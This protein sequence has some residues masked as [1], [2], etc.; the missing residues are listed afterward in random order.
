VACGD[1]DC[2]SEFHMA[3]ARDKAISIVGDFDTSTDEWKTR[4]IDALSCI[5]FKSEVSQVEEDEKL[6]EELNELLLEESAPRNTAITTAWLAAI[7]RYTQYGV[8]IAEHFN[9]EILEAATEDRQESVDG[10]TPGDLAA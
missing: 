6:V 5:D 4:A 7:Y 2:F 3:A 9:I 1:L 10:D 8:R